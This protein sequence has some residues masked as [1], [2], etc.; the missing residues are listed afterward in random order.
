MRIIQLL[1]RSV[2]YNNNANVNWNVQYE[3][4]ILS[5]F[6]F[7][8]TWPNASILSQYVVE[9]SWKTSVV[10]DLGTLEVGPPKS[11]ES[12]KDVFERLLKMTSTME[13]WSREDI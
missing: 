4:I 1:T 12:Q 10:S 6:I 7:L 3:Y 9:Y 2:V 11:Q 13:D 5:G 8:Q